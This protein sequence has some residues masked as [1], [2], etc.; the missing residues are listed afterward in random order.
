MSANVLVVDDDPK[1]TQLLRR[2]LSALD[3]RLEGP[4]LWIRAALA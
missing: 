4:E 1:I 3:I 2:T